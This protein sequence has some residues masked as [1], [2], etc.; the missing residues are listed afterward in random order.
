[1][2]AFKRELSNGC[3]LVEYTVFTF[4]FV[5]EV[6]VLEQSQSEVELFKEAEL[7]FDNPETEGCVANIWI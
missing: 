2:Y 1:M 6:K 3:T 5:A 4:K 7:V